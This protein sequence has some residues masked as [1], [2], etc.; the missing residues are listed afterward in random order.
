MKRLKKIILWV[1]AI[2]IVVVI[3]A[4]AGVALFFPKEKVKAMAVDKISSALDREVTIEGISVS[5]LGGIGAYL[6]NI[7]IANPERFEEEYF[8]DAEALDVKLQFWPLLKKNVIV[9]RLILVEPEIVLRKLDDGTTN[10]QFGV[11]D[12]LAPPAVK[13][14]LPE[15]SKLAVSAVSF[16]NLAVKNG[17]ISY[18]DDSSNMEIL[19]AGL[20]LESKVETPQQALFKSSGNI[21]IDSL[22]IRI[23]TV[24]YPVMAVKS[25]YSAAY[26]QNEDRVILNESELKINDVDL[27]LQAEIPKLT[28]LTRADIKIG[29]D[30]TSIAGLLDLL[31]EEY[32]ALLEGYNIDG[33]LTVEAEVKYDEST[34]DTMQYSG[35]MTL[36]DI[37]VST[38]EYPGDMVIKSGKAAFKNDYAD[39][40]ISEAS[41]ENNPLSLTC[42]INGFDKPVVD[43]AVDGKIDLATLK[44]Y[45]LESGNPQLTG[46]MAF[47][48]KFNGPVEQPGKMKLQGDLNVT[49]ATYSA[50]TLPEPI[51]ALDISAKIDDRDIIINSMKTKF[52][53]S[54]FDLKGKLADAFPYFIPGYEKEA[55]KPF[56]SFEMHSNRLDIDKLF[57]EAAPG[58]GENLTELPLDSLPPIILPDI[59]GKGIA[60]VDTLI[61]S[62]VE[63]SNINGDVDIKD[64]VIRAQNVTGKVY[65]GDVKGEAAIDLND[66]ENP[67]YSGKYEAAQIEVNDFLSRFTG[68]GGHLFGKVNMNGDFNAA[69]WEPEDLI[70]SLTLDGS[71]LINQAKLVNFD[72]VKKMAQTFNF[73]AS[74]EETIKDLASSFRVE[75]GRVM[76][77]AMTF[78]NNMGDWN[79]AGSVGFDGSL[80]YSGDVLLTEKMSGELMKSSDLVAGVASMLKE[81]KSERVRVGFKLGGTYKNPKP[82]LDLSPAKE[83]LEDKLKDKVGDALKGLFGK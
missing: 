29:A 59:D 13:E 61:Y 75:N 80:D 5:F 36:R 82:V 39:I 62:R 3:L 49:N 19:A 55:R 30:K 58:E 83:K 47:D 54:D 50:E 65:T 79:I 12:S 44:A 42:E 14:K 4:A 17:R 22:S 72:L 21:G 11:I 64:R 60:K 10:Y 56:L 16:E 1:I 53:S 27:R 34:P 33:G 43:G 15:E 78:F 26:N 32:R 69:G 40:E 66:F 70:K 45:L 20:K 52:T 68:L 24:S 23:D 81:D 77:D 46:E 18:V 35:N 31:P 41:F 76:F 37:A 57:P 67:A 9:D 51:E 48:M 73:S 63:F 74:D 6:E 71:A 8:L 25:S 28:E 38:S 2:G 7:K